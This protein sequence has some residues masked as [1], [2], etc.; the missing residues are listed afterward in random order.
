MNN[1]AKALKRI[2]S[3]FEREWQ[4]EAE[5]A[6]KRLYQ[7]MDGGMKVEPA[8]RKLQAEFP[9]LFSLAGIRN[10]LV[11]AAA[12][13]YGIMPSVLTDADKVL[14]ASVVEKSWS[15]DGMKLSQKLH[16]YSDKLY[17]TIVDTVQEQVRKNATAIQISRQL[18][19][20]Y[21]S[22]VD[23]LQRGRFTEDQRLP[24][25]INQIKR[26]HNATL[27]ESAPLRRAAANIE[28]LARN[29]APNRALKAGYSKLMEAVKS[30]ND[31]A[32]QE[33]INIAINEKSRYIAERIARTEMA[34]AYADGFFSKHNNDKDVAGYQ[35]EL[36]TR[37]PV[38]DVCDMYA[39]ADMFN[40]GKGVYPKDK[41]PLIPVHP[42]CL[43]TYSVLYKG[44]IDLSKQRN[45]QHQAIS[46][47]I[48][49]LDEKHAVQVMGRTG[50]DMF[51]AVKSASNKS[52]VRTGNNIPNNT[53]K[54][55][56]ERFIRN[57]E[58]LGNPQYREINLFN[59]QAKVITYK[60]GNPITEPFYKDSKTIKIREI[61][62]G[63]LKTF[64][65][66]NANIKAKHLHE[67]NSQFFESLG[68]HKIKSMDNMPRIIIA[69]AREMKYDVFGNYEAVNNTL[70]INESLLDFNLMKRVHKAEINPLTNSRNETMVHELFHWKEAQ[71]YEKTHGKITNQNAYVE[72]YRRICEIRIAKLEEKGYNLSKLSDYARKKYAVDAF[73]EV[74]TEYMTK[75]LIDG[76]AAV[77]EKCGVK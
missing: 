5:L 61:E 46:K 22:G 49:G 73:D 56:Y 70:Y 65:S 4:G 2:I 31:K 21:N 7:L 34:R 45:Q 24:K 17:Q 66:Q 33:A 12:Y 27:E 58:G 55:A 16:A 47:W 8:I 54:Y 75:L 42:H 32:I 71:T 57:Y 29:G 40:L 20:G 43:C 13:G 74:Y 69:S 37:H 67:L 36:S 59:G 64:V 76:E 30:D 41:L 11:E 19:D 25:Y 1:N 77:K 15:A 9:Q 18:Y 68:I 52:K 38:F 3:K 35:F 48:N 6:I 14:I 63:D 23:R 28:K 60:P 72:E 53:N 51:K 50:Y 10:A 44:Q 26:L 39:N 62:N